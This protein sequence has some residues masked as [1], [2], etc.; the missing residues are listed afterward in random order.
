M[1]SG[2]AIAQ[3]CDLS[4]GP[5]L[6]VEIGFGETPAALHG[7]V[8]FCGAYL[9]VEAAN[10]YGYP[11]EVDEKYASVV[12]G[13]IPGIMRRAQAQQAGKGIGLVYAD[14]SGQHG[15]L[16]LGNDCAAEVY[17]ANVLSSPLQSGDRERAGILREVMRVLKPGGNLILKV[18]W[19]SDAQADWRQKR[20]KRIVRSAGFRI[21]YACAWGE[22]TYRELEL[23]YGPTPQKYVGY[24]RFNDPHAHYVAY[25]IIAWKP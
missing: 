15:G 21:I 8:P 17:M 2:L 9:G 6:Y 11:S 3:R 14:A 12:L 22:P 13:A 20:L 7:T 19:G 16:P 24:A 10:G 25:F 5:G 18:S 23:R 4:I 1:G